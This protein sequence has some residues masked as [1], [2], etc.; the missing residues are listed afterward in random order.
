MGTSTDV[1]NAIK[2]VIM[3][4]LVWGTS[5][6]ETHELGK[7]IELPPEVEQAEKNNSLVLFVG[8][9]I[10]KLLDVPL[11]KEFAKNV[12]ED[13]RKEKCVDYSDIEQL[14]ESLNPKQILSIAMSISSSKKIKLD[15][16]NY[17]ER[18]KG[19]ESGNIYDTINSIKC[20]YVTTNYDGFLV[21]KKTSEVDETQTTEKAERVHLRKD[22][23]PNLA[24]KPGTV[25]HLHG[26]KDEP[27]KMV[28][29]TKNYLEHYDQK[30]IQD[31]LKYL[32]QRKTVVFLGYSLEETEILEHIF[33]R[34]DA[35]KVEELKRFVVTGFFRSQSPLYNKLRTYYE[36]TF[37][38]RLLGFAKDHENH[39]GIESILKDWANQM[40]PSYLNYEDIEHMRRVLKGG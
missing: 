40:N 11:W 39:R 18:R 26:Y 25:I 36:E 30:N 34:G 6:N 16:K 38:V 10:S 22:I 21:P 27:D 14:T 9:G 15:I 23:V 7:E 28:V 31:F 8:A 17:F 37:G 19:I 24:D 32:F 35:H 20:V 12:L 5:M 1:S 33:R 13:L 29:T 4:R 3:T 2:M